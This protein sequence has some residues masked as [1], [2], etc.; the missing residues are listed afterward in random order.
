MKITG[1]DPQDLRRP[2]VRTT[3]GRV[4][5]TRPMPDDRVL[6]TLDDGRSFVIDVDRLKPQADGTYLLPLTVADG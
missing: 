6:I 1:L 2:D 5:S 4:G 3:D